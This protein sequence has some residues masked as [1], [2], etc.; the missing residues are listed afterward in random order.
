MTPNSTPKKVAKSILIV[1]TNPHQVSADPYE[2]KTAFQPR[3]V[4]KAQVGTYG[5]GPTPDR[6]ARASNKILFVRI[7]THPDA[8]VTVPSPYI[9]NHDHGVSLCPDLC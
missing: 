3:E 1:R 5:P 7:H 8:A 6:P 9:F 4:L 2:V